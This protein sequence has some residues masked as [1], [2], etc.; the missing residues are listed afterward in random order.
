MQATLECRAMPASEFIFIGDE[1]AALAEWERTHSY[2]SMQLSQL[3]TMS[4][5]FHQRL[6]TVIRGWT[7]KSKRETR[8]ECLVYGLRAEIHTDY[9]IKTQRMHFLLR[10]VNEK[11]TVEKTVDLRD[12]Q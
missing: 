10:S 4:D 11:Y 2:K 8:A 7:D 1:Y 12:M 5:A 9:N 3:G 6:A